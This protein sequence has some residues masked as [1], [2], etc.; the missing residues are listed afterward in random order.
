M[1]SY[2]IPLIKTDMSDDIS[3]IFG[4]NFNI[5]GL[6]KIN[7]SFGNKLH[8]NRQNNIYKI[9]EKCDDNY[10]EHTVAIK[11]RQIVPFFTKYAA[12]NSIKMFYQNYTPSI[13]FYKSK[14]ENVLCNNTFENMIFNLLIKKLAEERNDYL[15]NYL[16]DF[17]NKNKYIGI[18][19]NIVSNIVSKSELIALNENNFEKYY[20]PIIGNKIN[21]AHGFIDVD[22]IVDNIY[23]GLV[24]SYNLVKNGKY[25]EKLIFETFDYIFTPWKSYLTNLNGE[26]LDTIG[27]FDK[28]ITCNMSVDEL[29]KEK[30]INFSNISNKF[31][32]KNSDIVNDVNS[33]VE[34]PTYTKEFAA[35]IEFIQNINLTDFCLIY[36]LELFKFDLFDPEIIYLLN[37][38]FPDNNPEGFVFPYV[39]TDEMIIEYSYKN[40]LFDLGTLLLEWLLTSYGEFL[41][42]NYSL[43]LVRNFNEE[44]FFIFTN[45]LTK[46]QRLLHYDLVAASLSGRNVCKL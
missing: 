36:N 5:S 27:R 3:D 15:V 19:S 18:I 12:P 29:M 30:N 33:I 34:I 10:F 38:Y 20:I 24:D 9:I 25:P 26:H 44:L 21:P 43:K 7:F 35:V 13:D 4:Y 40:Y 41:E 17:K 16:N 31:S 42:L 6:N 14:I 2:I 11:N 22:K 37:R 39:P 45:P 8:W 46:E 32:V 23:T 28:F 1:I